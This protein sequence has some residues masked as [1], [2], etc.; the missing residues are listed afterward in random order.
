[1]E[2]VVF[3]DNGGEYYWEMVAAD[4]ATLASSGTFASY[5]E[6]EQAILRF[7]DG[8]E[9]MTTSPARH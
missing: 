6:A 8:S 2:F 7:S 1:M 9:A 3:E 5:E 4:G